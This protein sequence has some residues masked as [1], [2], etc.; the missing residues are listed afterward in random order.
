[1]FKISRYFL[2]S[3][4]YISVS[5]SAQAVSPCEGAG[6]VLIGLFGVTK[7]GLSIAGA[8]GAGSRS[9][10]LGHRNNFTDDQRQTSILLGTTEGLAAAT[11]AF[12]GMEMLA[13][14]SGSF[15]GLESPC[16]IYERSA[17][18]AIALALALTSS[19]FSAGAGA[20]AIAAAINIDRIGIRNQIND[21]VPM[22]AYNVAA[23]ALSIA[24][25]LTSAIMY[26]KLPSPVDGS[27]A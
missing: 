3:L 23:A 1:M 12:S 9:T 8:V 4:L 14:F 10:E 25:A 15:P 13:Y 19:V 27:P 24:S 21:P 7:C 11:S 17:G 2:F 5:S 18:R 6:M 16:P 20:T 26:R 22:V